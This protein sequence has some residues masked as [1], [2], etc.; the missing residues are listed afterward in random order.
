MCVCHG[1]LPAE[2]KSA[3]PE[4]LGAVWCPAHAGGLGSCIRMLGLL[5]WT[6]AEEAEPVARLTYWRAG[7]W[8]KLAAILRRGDG[9]APKGS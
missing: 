3:L 4:K 1:H 5:C 6:M 7:Q 2:A 8:P 9:S